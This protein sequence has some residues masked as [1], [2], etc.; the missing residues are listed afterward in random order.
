MNCDG[1]VAQ[2]G[3]MAACGGVARDHNGEL[4]YGFGPN[5]NGCLVLEAELWGILFGLK[6]VWAR[7]F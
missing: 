5:F 1:V 3:S 2:H 6:V 7:G 4:I